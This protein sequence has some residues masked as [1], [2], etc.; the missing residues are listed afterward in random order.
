VLEYR[1]FQGLVIALGD[2]LA[3]DVLG[4]RADLFDQLEEH[5]P[6]V[7]QVSAQHFSRSMAHARQAGSFDVNPPSIPRESSQSRGATNP[8][9]SPSP[10]NIPLTAR[11]FSA[12]PSGVSPSSS[13]TAS[14][15]WNCTPSKPNS[16]YFFNFSAN[17]TPGRTAGPN[18]SAPLVNV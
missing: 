4:K 9:T 14:S 10:S 18:G 7:A 15:S 6:A 13:G 12:I 1:Q 3:L 5:G 16:L 17:P 8:A 11:A 2:A